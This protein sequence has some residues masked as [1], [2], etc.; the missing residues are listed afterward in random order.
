M[1]CIPAL[2]S[3]FLVWPVLGLD[4]ELATI[5]LIR[6]ESTPSYLTAGKCSRCRI[7]CASVSAFTILQSIMQKNEV[8]LPTP[9]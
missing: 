4:S 9:S 7:G 5:E 3:I 2:V 6:A 8:H 1:S